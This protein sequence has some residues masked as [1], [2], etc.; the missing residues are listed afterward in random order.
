MPCQVFKMWLAAALAITSTGAFNVPHSKSSRVSFMRTTTTSTT[1]LSVSTSPNKTTTTKSTTVAAVPKLAQ[2]WRKSTKQLATLGP[3]SSS[4]EMIEKLFLAGADVFRLNFSH[5]SQEQ[6]KELLLIIRE[7]EEKYA[8]P[9]AVLGDLQGPKLRVGEF[10]KPEGEYL[11]QGQIFRL[12][13][14]EAK[15]DK[16]RVQLPHPEILEA[17][18]IGHVLLVDDGKVKLTVVGKGEGYLDCRVDV[19]GKISNRKVSRVVCA[20]Q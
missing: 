14:D 18:E 6:K 19:E 15:G 11:E 16:K 3:A 10:S 9:I 20:H 5:G 2:R 8:H 13:L 17:S 12:D 1:A 7:I 4:K